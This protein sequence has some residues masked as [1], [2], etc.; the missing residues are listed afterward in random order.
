[1]RVALSWRTA[2]ATTLFRHD[3]GFSNSKPDTTP[4]YGTV[5]HMPFVRLPMEDMS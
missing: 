3:A 1:M 4:E 5:T 2:H